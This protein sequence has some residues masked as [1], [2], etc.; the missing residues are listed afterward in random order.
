M[1]HPNEKS[2]NLIVTWAQTFLRSLFPREIGGE[3]ATSHRDTQWKKS[4]LGYP[5]CCVDVGADQHHGQI[6]PLTFFQDLAPLNSL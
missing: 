5:F 1:Q 4:F 3:F 6:L 2:R